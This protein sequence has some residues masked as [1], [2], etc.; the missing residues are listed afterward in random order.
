M[1]WIVLSV[2]LWGLLHSLLASLKGKELAR[3]VFGM[4]VNRVYRLAYNVFAGVS[5][6]PVLAVMFLVSDHPLYIVPF[7]WSGPMILGEF[8]AVIVLIAGFFQSRPLEFLGIS[9]LGSS[10]E[11]PARLTTGGL[12]HYVRHPLYSAGL[13]FIWLMPLMTVNVLAIN[14]ALT[15]YVITGAYF[16]ER[17]LRREFGQDYANYMA[18]TPMFIPFLKGNKSRRESSGL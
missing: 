8:L 6:L 7:P 18:A 13:A 12:F 3:Q 5:F 10:I 14:I 2:L 16:E 17:K 1:L 9:Q 4:R 11:E 15:V